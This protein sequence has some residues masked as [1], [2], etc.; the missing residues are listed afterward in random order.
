VC[1]EFIPFSFMKINILKIT[2]LCA[3][4][5]YGNS[6][7]HKNTICAE[8][9]ANGFLKNYNNLLLTTDAIEC[10]ATGWDV[11]S[12]IN[13]A[14]GGSWTF[15]N[16]KSNYLW[17]YAYEMYSGFSSVLCTCGAGDSVLLI[18]QGG[19]PLKSKCILESDWIYGLCGL[20]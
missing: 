11:V 2:L 10:G 19:S 6:C 7:Y 16:Y 20:N 1:E 18:H 4:P 15:V 17:F 5:A 12:E 3:Y 8:S 14:C 13:T 9:Q